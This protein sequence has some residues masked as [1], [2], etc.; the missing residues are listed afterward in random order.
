MEDFKMIRYGDKIYYPEDSTN[1]YSSKEHQRIPKNSVT[2][3]RVRLKELQRELQVKEDLFKTMPIDKLADEIIEL[4]ERIVD[5]K[6]KINEFDSKQQQRHKAMRRSTK[7]RSDEWVYNEIVKIINEKKKSNKYYSDWY[8]TKEDTAITLR[9]KEK[10][11]EKAFRRL[12]QE[13]I[14]NQPVHQAPH[15]TKRDPNGFDG[16]SG[17]MSDMYYI[18]KPED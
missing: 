18:R 15:D 10:Q 7:K 3:Y 11:V 5:V 8:L 9:V 1:G 17:W 4:K 2:N 14:L 13:G 6:V 12:N 16:C